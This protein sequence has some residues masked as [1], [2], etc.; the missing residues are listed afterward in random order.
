MSASAAVQPSSFQSFIIYF[1]TERKNTNTNLTNHKNHKRAAFSKNLTLC[2]FSCQCNATRNA[3]KRSTMPNQ[4]CFCISCHAMHVW[5]GIIKKKTYCLVGSSWV[6]NCVKKIE[7][8]CCCV[9]YSFA[10]FSIGYFCEYKC[11]SLDL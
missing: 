11:W 10:W 2:S 9:L 7:T 8:S 4:V 5:I 6:W 3:R 1:L